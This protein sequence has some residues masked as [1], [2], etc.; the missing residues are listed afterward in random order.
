MSGNDG[1]VQ[2]MVDK[3]IN[4]CGDPGGLRGDLAAIPWRRCHHAVMAVAVSQPEVEVSRR[5]RRL[6]LIATAVLLLAVLAGGGV[7]AFRAYYRVDLFDS[8]RAGYASVASL[9]QSVID[10][11]GD[12]GAPCREALAA[13]YP[14][15]DPA[16]PWSD[17]AI[18][19]WV[20]CGSRLFGNPSDPWVV[21]SSLGGDD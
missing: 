5:R 6:G 9:P 19:F 3:R 17:Q 7:L 1:N 4:P 18:S 21:H 8:Y 14:A 11:G 10:Q 15:L 20:G 13:A 12:M 16:G 2:R